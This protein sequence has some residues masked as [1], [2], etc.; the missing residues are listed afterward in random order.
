M[1]T[2]TP[3]NNSIRLGA[4]SQYTNVTHRL[5]ACVYAYAAYTAYTA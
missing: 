4:W 5:Y 3:K 1:G 2:F